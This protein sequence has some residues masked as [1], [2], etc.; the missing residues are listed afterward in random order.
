MV[1]H[2]FPEKWWS[3]PRDRYDICENSLRSLLRPDLDDG[4]K[5]VSTKFFMRDLERF[6]EM[7]LVRCSF[8]WEGSTAKVIKR[9]A[10]KSLSSS[11]S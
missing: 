1:E 11:M 8:S 7:S 5:D 6:G 4:T 10:A 9:L 3:L 2:I